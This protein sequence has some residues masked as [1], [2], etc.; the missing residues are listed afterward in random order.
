MSNVIDIPDTGT[1]IDFEEKKRVISLTIL[2]AML[3]FYCVR[4]HRRWIAGLISE[5]AGREN[6]S[7]MMLRFGGSS[8]DVLIAVDERDIRN[9]QFA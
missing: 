2:M 1:V 6:N 8:P 5:T 4:V 3:I 9:I 7:R